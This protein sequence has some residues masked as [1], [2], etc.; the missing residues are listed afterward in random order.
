MNLR[1]LDTVADHA[2]EAISRGHRLLNHIADIKHIGGATDADQIVIHQRL[3]A[4]EYEVACMRVL[5]GG[6]P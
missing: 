5:I 3:Q 1:T 6:L 4:I 2:R